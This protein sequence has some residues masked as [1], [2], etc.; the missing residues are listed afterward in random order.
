MGVPVAFTPG[1]VPQ[2]EVLA[3]PPPLL[4]LLAL[5]ELLPELDP[6]PEAAVLLVLLLLPHPARSVTKTV[7]ASARLS[8]TRG[9]FGYILTY[10]SSSSRC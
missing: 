7:A 4:A 5:V 9:A 3:E 8:R 6:L 2:L 10:L 1:L